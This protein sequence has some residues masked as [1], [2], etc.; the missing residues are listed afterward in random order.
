MPTEGIKIYENKEIEDVPFP[1]DPNTHDG[2]N[3]PLLADIPLS[4]VAI[5]GSKSTVDGRLA[6]IISAAID[7]NGHF[8]DDRLNTSAKTILQAFAFSPADYSGAF[9]T[10]DITWNTTTG[11]I[12][13][14][15][16]GVFNKKGLIFATAG[17]AT[18]TLDGTTGAAT[19]AGALS[20]PS[21]NIGGWVIGP[22]A[23]Y[24]DGATDALSS[25][26]SSP[27]YPFYAGKKYANRATAPYRV[28]PAGIL[29]A[30][31]AIISGT[32]TVT[33]GAIGGW[34]VN[35]TSI[36]TGTEDHSGYTANAGDITIYSN[37]SDASIHAKN[38][39]ID[40]T[41]ALY[42]TS[43]TVSGSITT[44][45]GSSIDGQYLVAASVAS[46]AANLA[47]RGWTFTGTF[48][49]SSYR[50][51]AWTLGTFTASD[52]TAYSIVAGNTGNMS[53]LTY[54]Y[55]NIAVSTTALQTTTTAATAIGNGKVL[56]AIA[57]NNS[58]TT[59]LAKFQVFGGSGGLS[60]LV[61]NIVANSAATNT[62]I[63]NSAQIANLMVTNA[64]I[65]DCAIDKLTAGTITSKAIVLAVGDGTGDVYISGGNNIDYANWRGGDANGGAFIL[66]LDD[67]VANNPA[68]LFI[69]NYST[70]DYLS[71]DPTNKLKIVASGADGII[72]GY[73]SNIL[74]QEGG[75][76][77]FTSVTAPT[78]CTA[79]LVLTGTGNVDNGTHSYKVTYVNAFGETQLGAVS[80]TV[81]V[82]ATHKQVALSAIPV[83]TSGSVTA[84]KIYRTKAGGTNYYLLTT[85][86]NNSGTTYT[87]NTADANLTG[88][89]ANNRTNNS[90]GKIIIDNVNCAQLSSSNI[91][92]GPGAGGSSSD[93][94]YYNVA[95]GQNALAS[96]TT[97]CQNIAI[98]PIALFANTIGTNN[99][100]IG[101]TSLNANT[102]GIS[103]VAIGSS[104]LHAN[105]TGTW[106][107]AVGTNTGWSIATG[108]YNTA[109]GGGALYK[110]T[111]DVANYNVAVG[112]N[113][114]YSS[115]AGMNNV[116]VGAT[117]GYSN[118]SAG[119][120]VF[121]GYGAGYYETLANKLFI[122]NATRANEAD[123]RAKALIYGVFDALTANQSV[124][125]NGALTAISFSGPLT[126]NVTGNC[127]GT[128]ATVTGAT[129]AAITTCANLVTVGT[130][131]TGV[132]NATD[133]AVA[134]GGTG[135]SS[136][137]QYSIPYA[138]AA[139]VIS[140]I[141]PVANAILV[142]DGSKVPSLATDIPT[143]VT[144]GS[145]YIYR[146]DGTDV[147]VADGGT[148]LSSIA[149][150]SILAANSAN[151]LTAVT[152][153]SGTKY[154]KNA[155][156]TIS[157]D[158]IATFSA[159]YTQ[160]DVGVYRFSSATVFDQL[161]SFTSAYNSGSVF[162]AATGRYDADQTVALYRFTLDA[163]TKIAYQT[164]VRVVSALTNSAGAQTF[165]AVLG[166]YVY[167]TYRKSSDNTF[168]LYR[169]S[170]TDLSGEAEMTIS[171]TAPTSDAAG[172]SIFSDGT[173][174]YICTY[175]S[176]YNVFYKYSVSGTTATYVTSITYTNI[177]H[178]SSCW[179]DGTS[180]Y[181]DQTTSGV[182]KWAL[183]GG[184]R[185][186]L[187]AF[188]ELEDI[189][190]YFNSSVG[191]TCPFAGFIYIDSSVI[192]LMRYGETKHVGAFIN[193][194]A[195][196]VPITKP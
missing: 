172:N 99:V 117:A 27:D 37:G 4:N 48:S 83:S 71:Y 69:G 125:I 196:L 105:T 180:V 42:C 153:I 85:I 134:D 28:T 185:T 130:I 86:N 47:L 81:T 55:L 98:G 193:T 190:G 132:W 152:S 31:G 146:A 163:T 2:V 122:D 5:E 54:I 192:G 139:T 70:N 187:T 136:W 131:T 82:D 56:I 194:W 112:F 133:I 34:T 58:D 10:G 17:E 52:G 32:L 118:A 142:T 97:G 74:L 169:Y 127:S 60:V 108:N 91:F 18:I 84:R 166:S 164:Q 195:V 128:A 53:A 94:I 29:Y 120:C 67:S 92:I 138:S 25:G 171:G 155:D 72:I 87:D 93:V 167:A 40:T 148:N 19:F 11:A 114:G 41:G 26:M 57:Q 126:G 107:T 160:R 184:A 150:G 156:G 183:A 78:A 16:G 176:P 30:T 123:A 104:A 165:I 129:Q 73:G 100:A 144:I 188:L 162:Y 8:I 154:L 21:G 159:N 36:Y 1:E 43:A 77:K 191:S 179:C 119:G 121:I 14:G 181:D 89:I 147:S 95:I 46:A 22:T 64:K 24:Y 103:N 3:S 111:G 137:V 88:A 90:F 96:L 38:F 66:G 157:W 68:R 109:I 33:A 170:A 49:A 124:V 23:L 65:N 189:A 110:S 116:F 62:I 151:V 51:V 135:K 39:Y 12:T 177:S 143:A 158:T 50:T 61:D 168:H 141:S 44:G 59:S 140:E 79:T 149:A 161:A 45:S 76:L 178:G 7:E 186:S 182:G 173:Y 15:S 113:S 35:A 63:S 101:M 145:K 9:K 80:N 6:S 20:A 175:T 106:N 174:L 102:E 13:G 115:I 75:S